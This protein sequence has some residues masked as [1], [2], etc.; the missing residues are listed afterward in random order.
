[1]TIYW[2]NTYAKQKVPIKS[3]K[4]WESPVYFIDKIVK[5]MKNL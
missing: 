5:K 4:V 2:A 1:M 3:R